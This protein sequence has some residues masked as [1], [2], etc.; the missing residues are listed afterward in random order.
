MQIW[1]TTWTSGQK[2][3]LKNQA[4]LADVSKGKENSIVYI[5]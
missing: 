1:K 2:A 3:N 4:A 5:Y